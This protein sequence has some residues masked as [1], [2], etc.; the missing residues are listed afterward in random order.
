[1]CDPESQKFRVYGIR[2]GKLTMVYE[3]GGS[4]C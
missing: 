2:G 4:S 3:G 1:V